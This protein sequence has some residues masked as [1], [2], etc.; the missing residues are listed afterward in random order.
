M[1]IRDV[2]A[3][4]VV[5][6]ENDLSTM[7]SRRGERSTQSYDR[8]FTKDETNSNDSTSAISRKSSRPKSAYDPF[9]V[10][11]CLQD[12][13]LDQESKHNGSK[14]VT[15]PQIDSNTTRPQPT[16][17]KR[18]RRVRT[19]PVKRSGKDS[20]LPGNCTSY[21][22]IRRYYEQEKE[23]LLIRLSPEEKRRRTVKRMLENSR[24]ASLSLTQSH[25][26]K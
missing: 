14:S 21:Y 12:V 3:Y 25:G 17:R 7:Y 23:K 5:Y 11:S 16:A 15:F 18:L 2:R 4:N 8:A 20:L 22:S 1:E 13:E 19:A 6:K 9:R 26:S 24:R 10:Q